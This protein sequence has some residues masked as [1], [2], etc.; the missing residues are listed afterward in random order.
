MLV[1]LVFLLVFLIC[2]LLFSVTRML[3]DC[4]CLFCFVML[5]FGCFA[6]LGLL[7]V[8]MLRCLC[9]VNVCCVCVL[10]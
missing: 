7:F 5:G 1:C 4:L 10:V 8:F 6:L 3:V 9:C 2:A